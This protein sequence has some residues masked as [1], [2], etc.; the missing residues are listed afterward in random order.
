MVINFILSISIESVGLCS[1]NY[2]TNAQSLMLITFG[3]GPDEYSNETPSSFNFSTTHRQIFT[4]QVGTGMFGFV[5][6]VFDFSNS[7][8]GGALDHTLNDTGGYMFLV[9][10][11]EEEGSEFFKSTVNG[12]CIGVCYEF[13]AYLANIIKKNY[14]YS[15]PNVRFE[16][17]AT[18][19]QNDSLA[20]E[21]TGGIPQY[22]N[23]T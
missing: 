17:R 14:D 16:V 1:V 2:T 20:Q 3:S 10:V 5:N 15:K 21:V 6:K 23:M 22:D 13:S 12:L 11:A 9:D 7:W 19:W 18:A 8:H 4:S